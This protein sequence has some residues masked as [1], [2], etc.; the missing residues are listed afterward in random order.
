M[1]AST[2]LVD[3]YAKLGMLYFARQIFDEMAVREMP[4]WNA[5]IAGY[6]RFGDMEGATE[7]FEL[8]HFRNVVS[9]TA[10]VS[11]YSQ[12]KQYEKALEWFMRMEKEKD[13]K[14]NEVTLASVI[15]A[16][17]NLGAMEIGQRIEAYARQNGFSKNLYVS[18]A[19]LEMYARC[20]KIDVA[21]RVFDEIGSLRN[22]CSWNSMIMGLAVHGQSAKALELCDKMLVSGLSDPEI[23]TS[24]LC[25]YRWN[26]G[27]K[28]RERKKFSSWNRKFIENKF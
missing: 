21:W 13:I 12:N 20:G 17:A 4:T 16:C 9:W 18:N 2:A 1:F 14:P 7:L 6:A 11:G 28:K 5:M 23:P 19:I 22:L 26:I 27:R 3:M 8:M 15:P 25:F 24:T 10:M